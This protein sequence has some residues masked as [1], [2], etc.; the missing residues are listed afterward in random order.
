MSLIVELTLTNTPE[1]DK[2]YH[3]TDSIFV[4]VIETVPP[5]RKKK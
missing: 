2:P 3:H 1:F 4:G 5:R